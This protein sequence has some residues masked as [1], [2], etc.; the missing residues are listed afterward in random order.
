MI[1]FI[2][3]PCVL[4]V[5]PNLRLEFLNPRKFLFSAKILEKGYF[6]V[7]AVNV[8]IKI[9]QM[10]FKQPLSGFILNRGPD[11][12]VHDAAMFLSAEPRL[13]RVHAVWRELFVVRSQICRREAKA[14]A[15]LSA[16][17]HRSK[18]SKSPSQKCRCELQGAALDC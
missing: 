12:D 18:N 11:A 8:L 1:A 15:Q 16:F 17:G 5:A 4:D 13:C 9:K 7:L 14:P 6:D 2:N 10:Q 3:A